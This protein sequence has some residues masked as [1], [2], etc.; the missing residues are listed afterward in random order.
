VVALSFLS[1]F[2]TSCLKNKPSKGEAWVRV[3][4]EGGFGPKGL[5]NSAQ[6]L[7]WVPLFLSTSP[8]RAP[9]NAEAIHIDRTQIQMTISSAPSG[10]VAFIVTPPRLK[11]G[12]AF[13]GPSGRNRLPSPTGSWAKFPRPFGPALPTLPTLSALPTLPR[14]RPSFET[15]EA[16]TFA[17]AMADTWSRLRRSRHYRRLHPPGIIFPEVWFSI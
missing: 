10:L 4:F 13:Q 7:A 5:G 1:V 9:D 12:L 16:S 6:A 11:P 3:G 15:P 2:Q 14:L 17:K 8:V